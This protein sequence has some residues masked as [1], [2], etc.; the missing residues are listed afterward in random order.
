VELLNSE[1]SLIITTGDGFDF[2]SSIS[3]SVTVA[4]IRSS[5]KMFLIYENKNIP[6]CIKDCFI[7][8]LRKTKTFVLKIASL[9]LRIWNQLPS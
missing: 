2:S 6:V 4:Q 8:N 3:L 9:L 5:Y 1:S 7:L